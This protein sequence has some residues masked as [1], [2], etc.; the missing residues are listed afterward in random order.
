M[1]DLQPSELWKTLDGESMDTPEVASYVASMI[2]GLRLLTGRKS[3][4]DMAFLDY[5][6]ETAEDEAS[7]LA[8]RSFN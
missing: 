8:S 3:S 6:L 2:Q 7:N 5:L 1:R 4:A